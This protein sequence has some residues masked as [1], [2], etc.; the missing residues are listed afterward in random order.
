MMATEHA[1]FTGALQGSTET[2]DHFSE[3]ISF[4]R[5]VEGVLEA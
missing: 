5:Y 4:A 3:N 1:V 2:A